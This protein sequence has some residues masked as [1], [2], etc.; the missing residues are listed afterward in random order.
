MLENVKART[1][2]IR[3]EREPVKVTRGTHA[4]DHRPVGSLQ[5]PVDVATRGERKT[6]SRKQRPRSVSV[7]RGPELTQDL[8]I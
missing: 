1:K 8:F 6:V 5:D 4:G 7:S 3:D 2:Q